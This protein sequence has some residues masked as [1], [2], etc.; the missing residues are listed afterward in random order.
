MK[1]TAVISVFVLG[2]GGGGGGTDE[3]V[4]EL[5]SICLLIQTPNISLTDVSL[6]KLGR[7]MHP[8][9][10]VGHLASRPIHPWGN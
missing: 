6:T 1:F 8:T 9:S 7:V 3:A 2:G 4:E 10:A 5:C